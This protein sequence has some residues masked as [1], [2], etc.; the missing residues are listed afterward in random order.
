MPYRY[1]CQKSRFDCTQGVGTRRASGWDGSV[2]ARAT[3]VPRLQGRALLFSQIADGLR[4]AIG[5]FI[6]SYA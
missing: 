5:D 4:E 3:K 1:N 2:L 6:S